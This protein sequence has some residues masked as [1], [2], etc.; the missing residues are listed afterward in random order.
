MKTEHTVETERQRYEDAHANVKGY[1]LANHGTSL[2]QTFCQLIQP[3]VGHVVEL[4]AGNGKAAATLVHQGL[5]VT[6]MDIA[7]NANCHNLAQTVRGLNSIVHCVWEPWPA[8][9]RG[10]WHFSADFM[11]HLPE[12]QVDE[13]FKR[14]KENIRFGGI[15]KICTVADSRKLYHLTVQ[16][17][18]WWTSKATNYYKYVRVLNETTGFV[19]LFMRNEG[20][21]R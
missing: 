7:A 19:T 13:V 21:N 18:G 16:S 8:H 15:M 9:A 2:V 20:G 1:Q 17:A 3:D 11:E 6:A 5:T 14:L 12:D 10:E 4:G